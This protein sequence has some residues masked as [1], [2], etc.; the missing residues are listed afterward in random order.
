MHRIQV[1]QN[2][3]QNSGV[4]NDG[5]QNGLVVVPG[6]ANQNRT[7]NIVAARAEGT[8]NE[9]QVRCYNCRGLGHIARNCTATLQ[10]ISSFSTTFNLNRRDT[11]P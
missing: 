7:G 1:A 4:Q 9:N 3:V 2:A 8:G 5:N 10:Q 11:S 6:I